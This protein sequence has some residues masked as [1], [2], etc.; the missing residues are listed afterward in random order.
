MAEGD[1]HRVIQAAGAVVWRHDAAGL[2]VALVHRPRYDDWSHP[3]GKRQPG[4]HLLLT[5]VREVKEETGFDV[6]LGRPLRPSE[7]QVSGGAKRVSFWAGHC[8]EPADFTPNDEVDEV[9]WLPVGMARGRLSYERDVALL[10]ELAAGPVRTVPLI[11]LRHAEAGRKR[12]TAGDEAAAEDLGRP[13]DARG[14]AD[15]QA[16]AS[17][18]AGFGRC[19]VISSAAERCLATVRPYAQAAGVPVQPE[20]ALTVVTG[21]VSAA[22]LLAAVGRNGTGARNGRGGGRPDVLPCDGD[23]DGARL[24]AEIAIAGQ[25]ALICAHR[26]NLPVIIDAAFSALGASPPSAEPLAKSEFWVLH[27]AD[28]RLIAAERHSLTA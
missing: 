17:V 3:K 8:A 28:G 14:G 9:A 16:L 7:Y 12:D 13:L 21:G 19:Q 10:D 2:D 27:S 20:P 23:G 5:A 4:E 22:E 26:E 18:L 24:A 15:A 6:V 1:E 11:V 25:P